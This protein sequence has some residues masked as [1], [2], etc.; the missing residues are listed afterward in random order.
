MSR[1]EDVAH[2]M[3]QTCR[4]ILD[5]L[6][7][8][9]GNWVGNDFLPAIGGNRFGGRIKDLRDEGFVIES[10]AV[11]ANR[12]QYRLISEPVR[13]RYDTFTCA[14][15]WHGDDTRANHGYAG[16]LCP[17]CGRGLETAPEP[18]QVALI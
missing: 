17:S 18:L 3:K 7:Q 16:A 9:H 15:G 4:Q 11:G 10:K 13:D 5:V 2:A 1:R 14:C 6:R 12:W 8:A